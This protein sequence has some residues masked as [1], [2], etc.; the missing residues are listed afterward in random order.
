MIVSIIILSTMSFYIYKTFQGVQTNVL[1]AAIWVLLAVR[2]VYRAI[3]F[4][5]PLFKG[6][7]AVE[8]TPDAIIDH[9][10]KREVPWKDIE[11]MNYEQLILLVE[12]SLF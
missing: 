7:P 9:I 10:K 2:I 1:L 8:L 11:G 12:I 3:T 6:H 5:M 4:W